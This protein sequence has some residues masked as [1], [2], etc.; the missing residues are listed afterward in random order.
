M[1][2]AYKVIKIIELVKPGELG[3]VEKYK[4]ITFK[5]HGGTVLNV[6]I[7]EA[8]FTAEK[9]APILE[10]KAIEADKILSL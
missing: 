4:R 6:D 9:A 7:P 3:G 1:E 8:S 10:K 2:K 5:T